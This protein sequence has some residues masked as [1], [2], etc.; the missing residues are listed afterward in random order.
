MITIHELA[1]NIIWDTLDDEGVAINT[2]SGAYYALTTRASAILT[3]ITTGLTNSDLPGTEALLHEGLLISVPSG[4][5]ECS[6]EPAATAELFEKFTDIADLLLS[7]P[8]HHV[9]ERGWPVLLP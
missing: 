8:I 3:A 5:V 7:D 1:P 9:D 2:E 6:V 4:I